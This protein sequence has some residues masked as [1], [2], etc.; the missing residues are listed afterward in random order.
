LETPPVVKDEHDEGRQKQARGEDEG[1][2]LPGHLALAGARIDKANNPD[3]VEGRE[4]V[5][6]L[7]EQVPWVGFSEEIGVPGDEDE[8][9]EQLC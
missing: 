1:A 3:G 2:Q 4:Q 8:G 6:D 9:V 7:E 5:E